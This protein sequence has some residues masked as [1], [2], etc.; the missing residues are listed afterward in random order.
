MREKQKGDGLVRFNRAAAQRGLRQG[1][2]PVRRL[3][4]TQINP[5]HA[6]IIA[7]SPKAQDQAVTMFTRLLVAAC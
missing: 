2:W 4:A 7:T 5:R 1:T 3:E 6:E